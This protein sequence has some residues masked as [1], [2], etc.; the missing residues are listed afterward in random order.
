[1]TGSLSAFG[2]DPFSSKDLT[3]FA[4]REKELFAIGDAFRSKAVDHPRQKHL[5]FSPDDS[6]RV[7]AEKLLLMRDKGL[8]RK[9]A[10]LFVPIV[11]ERNNELL[12]FFAASDYISLKT[13]EGTMW[14]ALSQHSAE[15]IASSLGY[16]LPPSPFIVD[17]ISGVADVK[18]PLIPLQNACPDG[19]VKDD[20]AEKRHAFLMNREKDL[21][22]IPADGGER[23]LY[24][25][26]KKD[27]ISIR[28]QQFP[29]RGLI[30]G[31]HGTSGRALQPLSAA[32]APFYRDYSQAARLLLPFVM[33]RTKGQRGKDFYLSWQ[34]LY[35]SDFAW[36]LQDDAFNK[37]SKK[38][39]EKANE[40]VR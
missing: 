35:Q 17:A 11:I 30:Y 12:I 13:M 24:A 19:V 8:W 7:R 37:L 5:F 27:L 25:G 15:F 20:R 31:W 28:P 22:P 38:L 2:A 36:V 39:S 6:E 21:R 40:D 10:T 1:M 3:V 4:G 23:H 26:H 32:H 16:V 9:E 33:I 18:Y 34:D 14:P 29:D